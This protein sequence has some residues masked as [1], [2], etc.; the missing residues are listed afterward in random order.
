LVSVGGDALAVKGGSHDAALTPMDGIVGGDQT[1]AKQDLHATDGA[2]L[3]EAG[4]L[5]DE[6]FADVVGIVDEDDE[7]AEELVTSDVAIGFEEVFK[8]E[9]GM[10]EFDPGFERVEVERAFESRGQTPFFELLAGMG[11]GPGG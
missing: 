2:F 11:G 3:D 9:D 6:N 10:A 4:R 5:V 7:S 8:E 1:F